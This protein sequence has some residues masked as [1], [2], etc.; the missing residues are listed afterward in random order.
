MLFMVVMSVIITTTILIVISVEVA[1]DIE[2]SKKKI[3]E[4]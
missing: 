2:D 3:K 1:Q 4:L